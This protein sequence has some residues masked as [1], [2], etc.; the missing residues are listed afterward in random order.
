VEQNHQAQ[1]FRYLHAQRVLPDSALSF[2]RPGPIPFRP[3]EIVNR[4]LEVVDR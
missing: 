4:V 1:F 3:G 2:A